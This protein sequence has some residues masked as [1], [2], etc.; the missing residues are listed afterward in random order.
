MVG[1]VSELRR[2]EAISHKLPVQYGGVRN[3][4]SLGYVCAIQENYKYEIIILSMLLLQKYNNNVM[5]EDFV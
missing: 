1:H 4:I 3:G 5:A 2:G